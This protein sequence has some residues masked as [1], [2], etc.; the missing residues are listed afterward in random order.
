MEPPVVPPD[1][2][3]W[4]KRAWVWVLVGGLVA[5]GVTTGVVLGTQGQGGGVG[6]DADD[7]LRP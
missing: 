4:F 7:F 1:K 5:G 3:P 2:K 6:V